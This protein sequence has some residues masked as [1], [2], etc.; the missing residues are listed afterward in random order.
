MKKVSLR[1]LSAT[2]FLLLINIVGCSLERNHRGSKQTEDAYQEKTIS[3]AL[4]E[5][6]VETNS[7]QITREAYY[8]TEKAFIDVTGIILASYDAPV[9]PEVMQLNK[10]WGGQPEASIWVD[11]K[12]LPVPKAV[13]VNSTML[14]ALD[15]DD[16]H[17]PSSTHLTSV[18]FPTALAV[19]EFQKSTGKE[20]LNAIILGM[21]VAGRLGR[22]YKPRREHGGFL[23][24]SIIG[25]F[26]VVA[27]SARLMGLNVEQTINAFGIYYAHASGNRQALIDRTLTKRIQPAISARAG[28]MS[29]IMASKGIT[30][31]RNIFL[32]DYAGFFKIYGGG[33]YTPPTVSDIEKKQD[34]YEIEYLSFKKYTTTGSGYGVIKSAIELSKE[35]NIQLED[36]EKLEVGVQSSFVFTE[37]HESDN[38]QVL[39]QFCAPFQVA[40]ALKH[41]NFGPAQIDPE[42]I[43]KD[44]DVRTLAR[45]VDLTL[46]QL[47]FYE[48]KDSDYD[49]I[50]IT[51]K[52]GE[53]LQK[54]V[55]RDELMQP[56]TFDYEGLVEKYHQ[57]VKYSGLLSRKQA[58]VLLENIQNIKEYSDI[59][60]FVE[61]ITFQ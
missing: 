61:K 58:E 12:K 29:A 48:H 52:N 16:V 1:V 33:K 7:D 22:T 9:V 18:I 57:N 56:D 46:G 35:H 25:G 13:F 49:G 26:G 36:I 39:A 54:A 19:G 24:T 28:V 41:N 4:A 27:T 10:Q 59:S 40:S 14:H 5:I 37:W 38:P 45:K 50:R 17:R 30:G 53:V 15:F 47:D 11:G 6:T 42:Q 31:P 3:R 8:A 43:Q 55:N 32:S 34:Y 44:E 51:L 21:E 23:P 20:V 60:I 2:I